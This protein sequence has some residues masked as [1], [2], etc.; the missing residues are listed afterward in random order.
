MA[1]LVPRSGGCPPPP[2]GATA[3]TPFPLFAGEKIKKLLDMI[4]YEEYKRVDM[5]CETCKRPIEEPWSYE[6]RKNGQK[7]YYHYPDCVPEDIKQ[8]FGKKVS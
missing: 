1:G 5:I 4:W 8:G 3:L 2:V 7:V 6:A